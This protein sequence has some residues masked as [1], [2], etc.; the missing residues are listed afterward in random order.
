M[1]LPLFTPM[2]QKSVAQE[3]LEEGLALE[4]SRQAKKNTERSGMSP[5]QLLSLENQIK[6][7]KERGD[8]G[9][10]TYTRVRELRRQHYE[11]NGSSGG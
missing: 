10:D 1:T 2:Q 9:E 8:R 4:A 6:A 5:E 3:L 7:L 11:G